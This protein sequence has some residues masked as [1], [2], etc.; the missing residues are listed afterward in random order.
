MSTTTIT[1]QIQQTDPGVPAMEKSRGGSPGSS[2]FPAKFQWGRMFV[3]PIFDYALLGGGLSLVSGIFLY[4][5]SGRTS[6]D[7]T[8]RA[9]LPAL[10]VLSN[11]AHFAAST[12]RL[13]TKPG[14]Y[15][16]LPFLTMV[17]PLLTLAATTATLVFADF[18]GRHLYALYIAWSPYHYSA[19]AYGLSVMY[20]YRSGCQLSQREKRFLFLA[21]MT[22]FVLALCI[23]LGD[24]G[25]WWIVPRKFVESSQPLTASLNFL[26]TALRILAVALPVGLFIYI[27]RTRPVGMPWISL[28]I[29]LTNAL[30]FVIFPIMGAIA[31]TTVF[32]GIQYL[33][34]V[35]IFHVKDQVALPENKHGWAYHSLLFYGMCI[36]LGSALFRLWPSAYQVLGFSPAQSLLLVSAAIN[37]HHFI[38]DGYIW[39]LRKDPNYKIV[40]DA[41]PT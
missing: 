21:C 23:D 2:L 28:L 8:V 12:V 27:Q 6:V 14:A 29:V 4:Y 5:F 17:F 11:G 30:W 24:V 32:H 35:S 34:I 3:N 16:S 31:W 39:K 18:L 13:Y 20:C 25:I 41:L 40:T 9:S 22:T 10:F 33:A 36:L 1:N 19:Q 38:V 7:D 37:I 15:R 26:V